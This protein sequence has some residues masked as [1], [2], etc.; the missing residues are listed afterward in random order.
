MTDPF[1]RADT[2][3][4]DEV[5]VEQA[6]RSAPAL[7]QVSNSKPAQLAADLEKAAERFE[8]NAGQQEKALATLHETLGAEAGAT[9][10][11][12]KPVASQSQAQPV[13]LGATKV[14]QKPAAP[15]P[16]AQPLKVVAEQ[17]DKGGNSRKG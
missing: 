1:A 17:N 10:T 5:I 11:E 12:Q 4:R 14:E 15:Q 3:R 8:A 2:V 7:P 9:K 16:Q 6:K 13:E